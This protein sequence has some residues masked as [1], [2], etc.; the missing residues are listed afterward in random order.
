LFKQLFVEDQCEKD[1]AVLC[2]L[3]QAHGFEQVFE[4]AGI[5]PHGLLRLQVE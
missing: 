1:E 2:P 4:H 5:L 3:A